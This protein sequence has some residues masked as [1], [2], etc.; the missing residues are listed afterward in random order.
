MVWLRILV[1]SLLACLLRISLAS[2]SVFAADA[3][4]PP[5]VPL[6]VVDPY[7][8]IW[9]FADHLNYDSTQHWTGARMT[10]E[11][12]IRVDGNS[13]R[14]MG[15]SRK[16]PEPARQL[17]LH[18]FPT[19]TVYDFRAGSV[20]VRLTFLTPDLPQHIRLLSRPVTYLSWQ[21]RSL[22]GKPHNVEIYY[23]NTA[24]LVVNTPDEAV[25][26]KSV[27]IPKLSVLRM[28]TAAQPILG[29]AGDFV[30]IDWGYL[31][32]AAPRSE[33]PQDTVMPEGAAHKEFRSQGRLDSPMDARMPRAAED[34]WPVMAFAFNLGAVGTTPVSRHLILAYDEIYPIE[35]FHKRL[36]P[37]WQEGGVTLN[38][39]LE[40]AEHDYTSL[41]TRSEKF[42]EQL[43]ADLS[44]V[45]GERYAEIAALAYRQVFAS[46]KLVIGPHGQPLMFMKEISS[47]G[48]TQSAG[49]LQPES[50]MFLL[51]NPKLV[52]YSLEP[53]LDYADSPRWSQPYAP[54]DLGTYPLV[55]G[56][57]FSKMEIMP[58][59][60]SGD[61]ILMIAAV[62][63]AE[64]NASFAARY[65]PMLTEWAAYLREH[66]LDPGNQLSTDDFAGPLAH[67]A[68][69]SL[70]AIE[71]LGGYALLA[72][73]LGKK[74]QADM[75][76]AVAR[77]YAK[78]WMHLAG[79]GTH[80]LL[81]YNRPHTWSQKYNLAWDRILG[82]NLFPPSL[83]KMELAYYQKHATKWGFPL[84]SR[85]A[86]TKLD[87]ESW[88]ASLATSK[89]EFRSI[90]S[91][92]YEYADHTPA[93]VPLSDWYWTLDETRR[94]FQARPVVG[95]VYMEMLAHPLIWKKWALGR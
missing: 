16:G 20:G 33:F 7:F 1:L 29:R 5:A 53:L 26:W 63:K 74:Q 51:L 62:A 65:W 79:G 66:G 44:R 80:T 39:L 48:C 77:E 57:P 47:C 68:N 19:R 88:C 42:D 18:V 86:F 72:Q 64:G 54:H 2:R 45:G 28:G 52:E 75:Y 6:V 78:R 31:Y 17:S 32:V 38:D 34:H 40:S 9:S 67:S 36:R 69:L 95:S 14:I 93:R 41:N 46:N 12:L 87:W 70:H 49:V 10:M 24:E 59:E 23:D 60:H 30:R 3:F 76:W 89:S 13:Y 27:S 90:F 58:I 11:S 15:S 50:P 55:N 81:A 94:G 22:D 84:D 43:M 21:V 8:S 4:R 83:A 25:V 61:L 73:M 92:V 82:L 35:Y 56:R 91:V 37:Y 85:A 71:A